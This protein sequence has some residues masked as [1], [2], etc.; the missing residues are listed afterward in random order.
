[1]YDVS[2]A[3]VCPNVFRPTRNGQAFL[4]RLEPLGPSADVRASVAKAATGVSIQLDGTIKRLFSKWESGKKLLLLFHFSA[5]TRFFP[6]QRV[7]EVILKF[8]WMG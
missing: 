6:M 3:K 8:D 4:D 7:Q 1:M 2:N 5:P